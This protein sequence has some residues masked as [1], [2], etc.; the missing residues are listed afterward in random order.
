MPV[1]VTLFKWTDSGIKDVKNAPARMT[2]S[3]KIIEQHEGK[4]LGLYVIMGEYDLVSVTE[5]PNDEAAVGAALATSSRGIA[6]TST[7]RAFTEQEFTTIA[8]KLPPAK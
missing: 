4:I 6:R 3:R 8:N 2:E 7:M 1:Y 5:W